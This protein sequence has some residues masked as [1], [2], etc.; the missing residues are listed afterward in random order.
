[1]AEFGLMNRMRIY[2]VR[3]E[4]SLRKGL[5]RRRKSG[6]LTSHTRLDDQT[7]KGFRV[8]WDDRR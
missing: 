1:M 2:G 5:S 6:N 8:H 4:N 7:D 3:Q